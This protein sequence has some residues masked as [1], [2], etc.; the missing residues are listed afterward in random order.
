MS[1]DHDVLA[2]TVCDMHYAVT[3]TEMC[4]LAGAYLRNAASVTEICDYEQGL[5]SER[6]IAVYEARPYAG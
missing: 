1:V 6:T 5:A 4:D 2:C 3:I